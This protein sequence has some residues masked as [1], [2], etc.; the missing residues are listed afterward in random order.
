MIVTKLGTVVAPRDYNVY[1]WFSGH[2]IKGQGQTADL[3]PKCCLLYIFWPFG[4]FKL[5]TLVDFIEKNIPIDFGV[6]RSRSNYWSSYQHCLLNILWTIVL[7]ITKLDTVV[8]TREWIIH[9]VCVTL[10]NFAPEGIYDS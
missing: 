9:C 4:C 10:L 5:A 1:N 2:V 7:I 6:T 8:A 3:H